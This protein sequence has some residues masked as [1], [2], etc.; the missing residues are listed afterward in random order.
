M[1][2]LEGQLPDE[3]KMWHVLIPRS[4][5][6]PLGKSWQLAPLEPKRLT[7]LDRELGRPGIEPGK[8]GHRLGFVV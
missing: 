8:R 2:V 4:P 6:L 5:G 3:R 7:V 1:N